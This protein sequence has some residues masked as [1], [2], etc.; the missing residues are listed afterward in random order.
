MVKIT[1]L[2]YEATITNYRWETENKNI[3][4]MLNS[5]LPTNGAKGDDPNPDMTAAL[6]IIDIF[7]GEMIQAQETEYV[8]GR[9][10]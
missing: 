2:G 5:F 3:Q 1:T 9:I 10:Y 8:E 4:K 7:G 6:N